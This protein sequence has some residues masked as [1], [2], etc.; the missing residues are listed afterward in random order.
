VVASPKPTAITLAAAYI[1]GADLFLQAGGAQAIAAMAYGVGK[2]TP[3]DVIVGP[4]NKWVTAA[5]KIVSGD[6]AID[7]LAGPSELLIIADDSVDVEVVAADL[8]AQA[9]HDTDAIPVLITTSQKLADS[10]DD[11]LAEQLETL[12]TKETA[13][14]ALGNGFVSVVENLNVA[15]EVANRLGP[16]HLEL[17]VEDADA[18][19]SGLNNYGGLFIGNF[20]AEVFGDYGIGPNHVLPTGGTSRYTGGLSVFNFLRINTWLKMSSESLEDVISDTAKLA[21]H[22]GLEAH[23]RASEKRR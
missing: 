15:T 10:I 3:V 23:A 14:A 12:P 6:V 21:R 7:M 11:V 8:L 1:A 19:V 18:L 16:E 5:K 17:L 9:E 22:E 13:I 4:G 20:A 2:L